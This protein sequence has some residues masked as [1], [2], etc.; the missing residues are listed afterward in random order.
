MFFQIDKAD[1]LIKI[2][3][4]IYGIIDSSYEYNKELNEKIKF[5]FMQSIRKLVVSA[6]TRLAHF[7]IIAWDIAIDENN[8]P[9]IIEYNVANT[10]PDIN[11][12]YSQSFFGSLTD[13]ILDE[14]FLKKSEE[15]DGLHLDQY[16]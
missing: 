2:P 13:E 15:K 4:N 9:I 11:Q 7:K 10:I 14:V 12:M 3:R 5:K 16:I 1:C 6:A 8:N